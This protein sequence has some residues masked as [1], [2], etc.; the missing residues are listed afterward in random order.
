MRDQGGRVVIVIKLIRVFQFLSRVPRYHIRLTKGLMVIISI[1]RM[2]GVRLTMQIV[3][4]ATVDEDVIGTAAMEVITVEIREIYR[5][6]RQRIHRLRP[7]L[8]RLDWQGLCKVKE[9]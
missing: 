5:F 6:E 7:N 9:V 2:M 8:P 4:V 3:L 1:E